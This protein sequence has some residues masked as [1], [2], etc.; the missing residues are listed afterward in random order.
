VYICRKKKNTIEKDV[1]EK[2][3]P[4]ALKSIDEENAEFVDDQNIQNLGP[5][6]GSSTEKNP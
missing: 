1:G 4:P 3:R 2:K 5:A 6:R